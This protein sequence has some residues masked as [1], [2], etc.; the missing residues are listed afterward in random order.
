MERMTDS[1]FPYPKWYGSAAA[2]RAATAGDDNVGKHAQVD[3][4]PTAA[5]TPA[6]SLPVV[7]CFPEGYTA[8]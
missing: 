8:R 3:R 2:S 4:Q 5:R 6:A 1:L 7:R